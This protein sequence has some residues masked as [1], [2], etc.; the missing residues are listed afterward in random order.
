M[1]S[2]LILGAGVMQGPAIR[3][4]KSK[5]Y[6][7]YAADGNPDAANAASA[8]GFLH[9]DLKDKEALTLA[10]KGIA[11][12]AG[13]MTAG[14]DFSASVA[15][16][17]R[18]LGLPG[19][20]YE[21]ALD[22]S[23]KARM[24]ERLAAGGVA[25]PAYAYGS[26]MD[27]PEELA[28]RVAA[29]P[30]VVK[31]VDNMGARGCRLA[32]TIG[33][34]RE[35]WDD[36]VANSRTGRAIVEAYL[37]GP[38][39][40]IDAIVS[41]G[42]VA[43]RG[44]ADRAV[45]F[46][47]F[48]VEMGHTMPSAYGPEVLSE[49]VAVFE[50]G[51]AALGIRDGAAKGDIKYTRSGAFV[52]EIAARLSGGY[53]SGWTYPYSSG[54]EATAEAIDIACGVEPAMREPTLSLACSERAWISIPGTVA[55]VAGLDAAARLE[56]V[57]DVFARAG[58]GDRVVFPC[59]NVEKCG[60]VLAV[61]P[62]IA[63][64]DR[65]A[66]AAARSILVRLERGDA[67]T[68]GFLRGEGRIRGPGGSSWPP[69]AYTGLSAMTLASL[70]KMPGMLRACANPATVS[71]APLQ[72]VEGETALDWQG[73]GIVESLQAVAALTGA[74]VGAHGEAVL[75]SSFWRALFRGGY[76]AGAWV[77]DGVVAGGSAGTGAGA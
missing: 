10:A 54:I 42:R 66:E 35:A 17:A 46:E 71:I 19:I 38:E 62:D 57:R 15:W 16:V 32:R 55:S 70:D 22:A 65:L 4:A 20:P 58:A 37:E 63:T 72:G 21:V 69:E 75:G 68:A 29:L 43:L 34:L 45:V 33:E 73:R 77:V 60:N 40:S 11:G 12:L 59:N 8:D 39:F 28:S 1:K 41:G 44:V 67:R 52:G 6:R 36:A 61:A 9:V 30:L 7:T 14:T 74:T 27:D 3:I 5:G 47:P 31:P 25:V 49:V 18:E 53:M 51:V 13:V 24:R 56:G 76:Q 48:F 26:R 23:D 50:K 2:I 64:A